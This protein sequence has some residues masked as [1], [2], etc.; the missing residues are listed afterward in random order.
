MDEE[1]YAHLLAN[2]S[3]M[4]KKEKKEYNYKLQ[5]DLIVILN[6]LYPDYKINEYCNDI[7]FEK[8]EKICRDLF[9]DNTVNN[10]VDNI[11]SEVILDYEKLQGI[12]IEEI[13]E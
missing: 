1:N 2:P 13:I 4:K 8:I 7:I 12:S 9:I 11:I 5:A 10:I 6:K 3:H